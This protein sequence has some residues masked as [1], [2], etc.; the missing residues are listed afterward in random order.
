M[1]HALAAMALL[2]IP[3]VAS[4]DTAGGFFYGGLNF[5]NYTE[6]YSDGS[7]LELDSGGGLHLN[8]GLRFGPGLMLSAS[9]ST[10]SH[11]GGDYCD[12]GC[13]RFDE[14]IEL[15]EF[16]LG[17][18]YAPPQASVVGFRVG[19]GY[20]KVGL[21]VPAFDVSTTT[22]GPFVQGVLLLKAGPVAL[23]DLGLALMVLE[24][25]DGN[26]SGG[27]EFKAGVTFHTGAV[28]LGLSYRS[29]ALNTVY[30]GGDEV[31]S[32]YGELRLTIGG[33]WGYPD[34]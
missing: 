33:T 19:G 20:E 6:E 26:D 11:D 24:D 2:A 31:D 28:D 22:K 4:A 13:L 27:A 5:T 8:G 7:Q 12:A 32:V 30:A 17:F 18:Y 1:K 14:K 25:D 21:E 15:D 29:L 9:Y 16:R 23:F 3:T 10:S 34:K